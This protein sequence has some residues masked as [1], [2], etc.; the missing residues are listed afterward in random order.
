MERS[1]D[2]V[3]VGGGA[4]GLSAALV[5]GRAGRR[6]LVVDAGAQSNLAAAGIG[7]LLGHDGTPPAELY[8][9]GRR[10]LTA[11]PTVEVRAGQ[12]TGAARE[13]EGFV[14]RLADGAVESTRRVLL[15]TGM[16]YR[17]PDVPGLRE[18]WGTTVFHCPFCHGWEVR[19]EPL[20][21]LAAGDRAMHAALLLRGWTEDLVVLT[22]GAAGFDEAD[23][24]RLAAAGIGL[25]ERRV[26]ALH[27]AD[28]ALTAVEFR[29]GDQLARR[30]LMVATTLHQRSALA[31]ELGVQFGAN[32]L[33]EQ[34]VWTDAFGRTSVRG[35]FAAGDVTAQLPQ[36]ATAIA[37][38]ST[39]AA[40]VV[41]SLLADENGLAVPPWPER[42]EIAR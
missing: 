28:G 7:G 4:A 19:G 38:G 6:T 8:A 24:K 1:W 17:A 31:T 23:E 34:A 20:A 21:V 33:A 42:E 35:V 25:D 40:A 18:L 26:A 9:A 41:Q 36:V 2:C 15:A 39:A 10:E 5:L 3:V 12:V 13:G 29:D 37:A 30:G 14:M 16:D 22:D 32:P 27:G 11:Y